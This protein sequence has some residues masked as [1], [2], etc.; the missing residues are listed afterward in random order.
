M[1]ALMVINMAAALYA[2]FRLEEKFHMNKKLA[3]TIAIFAGL[4]IVTGIILAIVIE[5]LPSPEK[6]KQQR[7]QKPKIVKVWTR[8]VHFDDENAEEEEEIEKR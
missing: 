7:Q 1:M 3:A 5:L 6:W 4:F 2:Y 8:P